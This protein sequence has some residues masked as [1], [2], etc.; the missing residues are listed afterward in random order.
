LQFFLIITVLSVIF[1]IVRGAMAASSS[2]QK[3]K[4]DNWGDL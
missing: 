3:K 2:A 1:N 4:D